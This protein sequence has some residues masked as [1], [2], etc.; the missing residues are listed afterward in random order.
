M[1]DELMKES[2][3]VELPGVVQKAAAI[4][5]VGQGRG[6]HEAI[7]EVAAEAEAQ[8]ESEAGED[9]SADGLR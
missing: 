2:T 8:R 4:E 9:S 6:P 7:R 5:A 1:E 3:G